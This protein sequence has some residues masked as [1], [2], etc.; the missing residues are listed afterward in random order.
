M[1]MIFL[2][3]YYK[4]IIQEAEIDPNITRKHNLQQKGNCIK[5]RIRISASSIRMRTNSTMFRIR[6][7][8]TGIHTKAM[9]VSVLLHK[10]P[11][12]SLTFYNR[13]GWHFLNY[14]SRSSLNMALSSFQTQN[15]QQ[16]KITTLTVR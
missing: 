8:L 9:V 5:K 6:L 15:H 10:T 3:I 12:K 11:T 2:M 13:I 1:N 14:T 4:G 16:T 7:S